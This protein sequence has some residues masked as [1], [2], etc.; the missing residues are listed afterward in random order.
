MGTDEHWSRSGRARNIVNTSTWYWITWLRTRGSWV[1]ILPGAPKFKDLAAKTKSSQLLWD[2]CGT[3]YPQVLADATQFKDL[4]GKTRSSCPAVGLCGTSHAHVRAGHWRR[5]TAS[6]YPFGRAADSPA[7]AGDQHR[8]S[9]NDRPL[10]DWHRRAVLRDPLRK[11]QLRAN[12]T[13]T[14]DEDRGR[15]PTA[16]LLR[17]APAASRYCSSY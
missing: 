7:S 16:I 15:E 13:R 4:A 8:H 5:V 17:V 3:S 11:R 1:Q 6:V 10:N 14:N 12:D 9:R 2:H